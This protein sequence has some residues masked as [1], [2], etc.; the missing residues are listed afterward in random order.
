MNRI[1]DHEVFLLVALAVAGGLPT[2]KAMT[3]SNEFGVI[4]LTLDSVAD[5]HRWVEHIGGDPAAVRIRVD[6]PSQERRLAN[7]CDTW[8]GW[9]LSIYATEK[10]P[11][12]LTSATADRVRAA[13]SAVTA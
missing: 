9:A 5:G 3:I 1:P 13:A 4:N 12:P 10:L 11:A 7:G 2:P 6:E 8:R